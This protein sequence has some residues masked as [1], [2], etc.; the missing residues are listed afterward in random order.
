MDGCKSLPQSRGQYRARLRQLLIA[1]VA[2]IAL[3]SAAAA[4]ADAATSRDLLN[5]ANIQLDGA[6]DNDYSVAGAGD[7][8]AALIEPC[9][10]GGGKPG[11]EAEEKLTPG[12]WDL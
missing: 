8:V 9:P 3:L 10:V 6:A 11:S 12:G 7:A 2:A 5:A 1:A 4:E